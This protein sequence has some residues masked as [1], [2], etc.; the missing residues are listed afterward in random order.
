MKKR[1]L[2]DSLSLVDNVYISEADPSVSVKQVKRKRNMRVWLA[3]AACFC[4]A[5]IGLNLWLFIPLKHTPPSVS[6]YSDSEYYGI[7]VKLNELTYRKPS[8]KNNYERYFSGIFKGA[9]AEDMAMTMDTVPEMNTAA[10]GSMALYARDG[11][12][13][14]EEVT[15]NQV[16]G[17]IEGDIFKRSSEHIY[18]LNGNTLEVYSINKEDSALIGSLAITGADDMRYTYSEVT[19]YLSEDCNTVTLMYSYYTKDNKACIAFES[20]DVSDPAA[21][22][23]KSRVRVSGTYLSSRFTGGDFIHGL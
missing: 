9:K 10:T 18:Y 11:S 4:C 17:V 14:Y 8:Y 21:M 16:A 2:M 15:D 22:T 23:L 6:Q 5:V 20:I 19:M 12:E 3:I 7:I 1:K 13:T